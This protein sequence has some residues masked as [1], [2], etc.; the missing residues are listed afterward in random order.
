ME[1][2]QQERMVL[3]FQVQ[4]TIRV[5]PWRKVTIV[6]TWPSRTPT[7]ARLV[8]SSFTREHKS[9]LLSV[10]RWKHSVPIM[11]GSAPR[12]SLAMDCDL[13]GQCSDKSCNKDK[14]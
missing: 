3:A 4:I 9:Q 12:G 7:D 6:E 5:N 1:R 8:T 13:D 14:T 2:L 10:S 11:V